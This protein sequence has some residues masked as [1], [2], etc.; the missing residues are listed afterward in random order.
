MRKI[1]AQTRV[2]MIQLSSITNV[3][4]ALYARLES[5]RVVVRDIHDKFSD[6]LEKFDFP[7]VIWD[8]M[9]RSSTECR[10]SREI[11][12]KWVCRI[13]DQLADVAFDN[14]LRKEIAKASASSLV[15]ALD[16]VVSSRSLFARKSGTFYQYSYQEGESSFVKEASE[17][18]QDSLIKEKN[19]IPLLELIY[20]SE[21]IYFRDTDSTQ[22]A[23]KVL[24]SVFKENFEEK[25]LHLILTKHVFK[26]FAKADREYTSFSWSLPNRETCPCTVV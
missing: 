13:F 19:S 26:A 18:M 15:D 10:S 24:D 9:R 6:S 16:H 8:L 2:G 20:W 22:L 7:V 23:L 21:K 4:S 3:G 14:P 1:I 12:S 17:D 5:D 11:K 25:K